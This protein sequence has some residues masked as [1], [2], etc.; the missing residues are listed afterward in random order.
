MSDLTVGTG[1]GIA[2]YEATTP[3][4]GIAPAGLRGDD[5]SLCRRLVG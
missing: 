2:G 1:G 3:V 5:G 4:T